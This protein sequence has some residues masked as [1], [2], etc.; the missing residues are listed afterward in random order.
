MQGT[1][2]RTLMG[3]RCFGWDPGQIH[4]P[5]SRGHWAA[6]SL[7]LWSGPAAF[8]LTSPETPDSRWGNHRD[9]DVPYNIRGRE[10]TPSAQLLKH[11]E[12]TEAMPLLG[13]DSQGGPSVLLFQKR[14][15]RD[16]PPSCP[17]QASG[18]PNHWKMENTQ[19]PPTNWTILLPSFSL[20][21]S[22]GF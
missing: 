10:D 7:Y 21:E 19:K 6:V 14:C 1:E 17:K 9:V 15:P 11:R 16:V 8:P 22:T 5:P 3:R 13:G 4:F 2:D 20:C 18:A 12:H